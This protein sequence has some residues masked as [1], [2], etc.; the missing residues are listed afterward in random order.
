MFSR[1]KGSQSVERYHSAVKLCAEYGGSHF[2][3]FSDKDISS[4]SECYILVT[5]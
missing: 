5:S 2:E 4:V 3:Q 1:I